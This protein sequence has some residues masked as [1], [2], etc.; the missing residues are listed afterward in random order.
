VD[1]LMSY[2]YDVDEA[3]AVAAYEE[4]RRPPAPVPEELVEEEK[5][6][7]ELQKIQ[8]DTVRARF[9]AGE[10]DHERL[11]QELTLANYHPDVAAA[12][13]NLEEARLPKPAMTEEEKDA[14]KAEARARSLRESLARDLYRKWEITEEDLRES[15]TAL[16]L[17]PSVVQ[18]IVDLER[19]RRPA[20]PIP[21]AEQ[22]RRRTEA[23]ARRLRGQIERERYRKGLIGVTELESSLVDAGYQ[24]EIAHLIAWYEYYHRLGVGI[25]AEEKERAKAEAAAEAARRAEEKRIRGLRG[26]KAV[27]LYKRYVIDK[28]DLIEALTGLGFSP[29]EASAEA[30]LAETVRPKPPVSPEEAE[31]ERIAREER[32]L[33]G[34][35]AKGR[36]KLGEI[37]A[38]DLDSRLV[39]LRYPASIARLMAINAQ[40][41]LKVPEAERLR[42]LPEMVE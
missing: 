37:S 27:A 30:D 26:Q 31:R 42:Y 20:E 32:R 39:A 38:E 2:D 19:A 3:R 35:E 24:A 8:G 9:R 23:E 14:A 18:A 5:R 1:A 15:L 25:S 7:L 10:I 36:Y 13:A 4:I 34:V 29:E 33:K 40:I 16:E 41:A 12:L 22:E 11:V 17:F 21:L 28:D 6:R